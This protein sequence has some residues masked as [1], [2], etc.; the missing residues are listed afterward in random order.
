[1]PRSQTRAAAIMVARGQ[2]SSGS[3]TITISPVQSQK[4]RLNRSERATTAGL[5]P[6]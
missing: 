3:T 2:S 1:M 4:Q 5:E 6:R